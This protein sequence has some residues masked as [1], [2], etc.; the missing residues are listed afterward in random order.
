M[1]NP[2]KLDPADLRSTA[3]TAA[4]LGLN[5]ATPLRW[6]VSHPTIG[7]MVGRRFKIPQQHIERMRAG[8]TVDEVA[9]NPSFR[10][11]PQAEQAPVVPDGA[12]EYVLLQEPDPD[13]PFVNVDIEDICTRFVIAW[14]LTRIAVR[15]AIYDTIGELLV[16]L[17]IGLKL[18]SPT[19]PYE[20]LERYVDKHRIR[21]RTENI[22]LRRHG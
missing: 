17:M 14:H 6:K 18:L 12:L 1:V 10:L 3:E 11:G 2:E 13:A 22:L 19:E 4:Q 8:A 9:A 20:S 21:S 5:R 16:D 7:L 15:P